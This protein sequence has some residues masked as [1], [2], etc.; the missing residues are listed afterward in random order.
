MKKGIFFLF[1]LLLL[2]S[3]VYAV[4]DEQL[5]SQLEQNLALKKQVFQETLTFIEKNPKLPEVASLYS[6]LAELSGSINL[7][8]PE[9]TLYYYQQVLVKDPN[10]REK[11]RILY[12]I[13]FYTVQ[14]VMNRVNEGRMRAVDQDPT[15]A[16]HYPDSL[17]INL[18]DMQPAIDAYDKLIKDFPAS[19][20]RSEGIFRLAVL[21]YQIGLDAERPVIYYQ[22]AS[23][24]F[25]VLA[26][27]SKDTL[28]YVGLFQRGWA[29][30]SSGLYEKSIADFCKILSLIT[31]PDLNLQKVYFEDASIE[32][33]AYS[34]VNL[35]KDDYVSSSRGAVYAI[36]QLPKL[37]NET[38]GKEIILK[39]VQLKKDLNAPMQAVDFY[40]AYLTL[41]PNGLENPSLVDS[42]IVVYSSSQHELRPNM[43][44]KDAIIAEKE[45]IIKNYSFNT[46]WYQANQSQDM[47][48]PVKIVNDAYA[49]LEPFYWNDY[50]NNKTPESFQK[51]DDLIARFKATSDQISPTGKVWTVEKAQKII[52][53]N[54]DLAENQ[55][56]PKLYYDLTQRIYQFNH[57]YPDNPNYFQ[58]EKMAFICIEKLQDFLKDKYTNGV[59]LD[60]KIPFAITS[61]ATD[62]LYV[63]GVERYLGILLS[64]RNT[65]TNKDDETIHVLYG[66]SLIR[67]KFGDLS[68]ASQDLLYIS[69]FN[70]PNNTRRDIFIQLALLNEKGN[71]FDQAAFYYKKAEPFALNAEDRKSIHDN[72]LVQMNNQADLVKSGNDFS[73]AAEEYLKL[74]DEFENTDKERV[75]GY[76]IEAQKLYNKAGMYQKGINLLLDV[77]RY[78]NNTSDIYQLYANAWSIADSL[79]SDREQS[80]RLKNE[81]VSKY[82]KSVEAY[83]TRLSMINDLAQN[84]ATK[85]RA[86]SMYLDIYN[87]AAAGRI[88]IGKDSMEDLYLL[89]I[90]QY[91]DQGNNTKVAELTINFKRLYP[92]NPKALPLLESVASGYQ[93]K[94]NSKEYENIV[95]EIY[96]QDPNSKLFS[97]LAKT[98][99]KKIYD[100]AAAAYTRKDWTTTFSKITEFKQLD[101]YYQKQGLTLSLSGVYEDFAAYK[102]NYDAQMS[103]IVFLKTFDEKLRNIENGFVKI[104]ASTLLK[105]NDRTSWKQRLNGG[106][107]RIQGLIADAN[108]N[109]DEI[110]KLLREANN[111]DIDTKRRTKAILLIG[112]IY[113]HAAQV[114]D[115][116][117][118]KY[119][120]VSWEILDLKANREYYKNVVSTI[121]NTKDE[122][123]LG[124]QDAEVLYFT[125]MIKNF[126]ESTGYTDSNIEKARTKLTEM[127]RLPSYDIM[128]NILDNT[129]RVTNELRTDP[130]FTAKTQTMQNI[131]TNSKFTLG[132]I[133]II[134]RQSVS[135]YKEFSSSSL[136][137]IAYLHIATNNA[138]LVN[139]NMQP[140]IVEPQVIDTVLVNGTQVSHSLIR[141][142]NKN[143][144]R[145]I[146]KIEIKLGNESNQDEYFAANLQV[147]YENQSTSS[148]P[149]KEPVLV[150]GNKVGKDEN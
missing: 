16:I 97:D 4:T 116:Q 126:S 79:L 101:S 144:I 92:N 43:V 142:D 103:N 53:A 100:E 102:A 23:E 28:Q 132:C 106:D 117:I 51:Y 110:E 133:K 94:D 135:V 129:W 149:V 38:Y 104:P 14:T 7:H 88:N 125:Y 68:G 139:V 137:N 78:R 69:N 33:V 84:P 20:Y 87:D 45:R 85:D 119:L 143:L 8:N 29:N 141:I 120:S 115:V 81:F 50:V 114:V 67:Q 59:Y 93:D 76:K 96:V 74:A 130:L 134:P 55:H 75:I 31:N 19:T 109:K 70:L 105:V 118:E 42:I 5:Q 145:G 44:L 127:N 36:D 58:N 60:G 86:A 108:R 32:N 72:Y 113:D 1:I 148:L 25:D 10:F 62:S 64:D 112:M 18:Q 73:K 48:G 30:F 77:S 90:K 41:Y 150:Q 91:K 54:Y 57:D 63:K 11:D 49:F 46:P 52:L 98:K 99:L 128:E 26:N 89:A 80:N 65:D 131:T 47:T 24:L 82:P 56:N 6:N 122:Y 13:G 15:I 66:R 37:V 3:I 71:N 34:F 61:T 83:Q 2:N 35:D 136:P 39:A 111:Y 121:R 21:Y 9:I 27:R 147:F 124:L 138:I 22:K 12:N 140:L 107:K 17:R 95:T 123:V 146:N 40:N